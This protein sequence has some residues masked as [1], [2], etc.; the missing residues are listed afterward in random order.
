MELTSCLM[1]AVVT[2]GV[3]MFLK[4]KRTSRVLPKFIHRLLNRPKLPPRPAGFQARPDFHIQLKELSQKY[5][6]IFMIN[7]GDK[8]VAV[9]TDPDL[10]RDAFSREEFSGRPD[11]DLITD[12]IEGYGKFRKLNHTLNDIFEYFKSLHE[13]QIIC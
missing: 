2:F 5:G 10:I 13:T 12:L 3:W 7:F 11:R 8:P 9:L 1:F 6:D 4:P